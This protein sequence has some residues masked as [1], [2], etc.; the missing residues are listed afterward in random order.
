MINKNEFIS[1]REVFEEIG[2]SNT[3]L[4]PRCQT[5]KTIFQKRNHDIINIVK[6]IMTKHPELV[7]AD[8]TKDSADPF[9]I[10]CAHVLSRSLDSPKVIIV[11]QEKDR[12]GKIPSV[13]KDYN[14][15]C[16]N[17]FDFFLRMKSE[18]FSLKCIV[19]M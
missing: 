19:L 8:R 18:H 9:I 6:Q 5:N 17:L 7:N 10:A 16:M 13:A 3:F 12:L 1:V 2:K 14:I 4:H 11:T 15:E